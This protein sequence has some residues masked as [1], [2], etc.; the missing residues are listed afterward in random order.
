M[1]FRLL[2][3]QQNNV[4]LLCRKLTFWLLLVLCLPL[5]LCG[6]TETPETVP[7]KPKLTVEMIDSRLKAVQDATGLDEALK[8][9]VVDLYGQAKKSLEAAAT[10]DELQRKYQQLLETLPQRLQAEKEKLETAKK[11]PAG[12]IALHKSLDNT[13]PD[14]LG[15]IEQLLAQFEP[16]L[17]TW[18][19]ELDDPQTGLRKKL[20]DINNEAARRTKRIADIATLNTPQ[21][22]EKTRE[23][24]N[25]PTN[26]SDP[27]EL[28]TAQ[29]TLLEA[30]AL[31]LENQAAAERTELALY[32]AA[33]KAGLISAARCPGDAN[34]RL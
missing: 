1:T 13:L 18:Q 30:R 22:L 32:D 25:M 17:N 27:P 8:T 7:E 33:S 23:Q 29:K 20:L 24:L 12:M 9:K 4:F 14:D 11:A 16:E 6:Q 34:L 21:R 5:P 2:L 10:W 3:S 19:K 28:V 15:K 31:E 26:P